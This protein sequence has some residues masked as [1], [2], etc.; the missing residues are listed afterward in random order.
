Q[1]PFKLGKIPAEETKCPAARTSSLTRLL[2]VL[3]LK[4]IDAIGEPVNLLTSTENLSAHAFLCGCNAA[5]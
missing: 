5:H 3:K 4:G 2:V 1:F